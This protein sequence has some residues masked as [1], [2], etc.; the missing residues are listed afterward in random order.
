MNQKATTIEKICDKSIYHG[1]R[2]NAINASATDSSAKSHILKV[3][4]DSEDDSAVR[5]SAILILGKSKDKSLLPHFLDLLPLELEREKNRCIGCEHIRGT[6]ADVLSNYKDPKTLLPLLNALEDELNFQNSKKVSRSPYAKRRIENALLKTLEQN[7]DLAFLYDSMDLL[8]QFLNSKNTDVQNQAANIL[9]KVIDSCSS[10]ERLR[11]L[12]KR[13]G[14]SW[15]KLI[16]QDGFEIQSKVKLLETKTRKKRKE[17]AKLKDLFS[18]AE[19]LLVLGRAMRAT[20]HG[21]RKGVR[22]FRSRS[23]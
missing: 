5:V 6:I 10:V 19:A 15:E 22:R 4:L 17:H 12:E 2:T 1:L 18:S 21:V 7:P 20:K 9:E 23:S 14:K 11:E 16:V 8:V 3:A 13:L